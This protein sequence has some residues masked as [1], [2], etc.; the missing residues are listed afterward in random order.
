MSCR[1]ALT[2]CLVSLGVLDWIDQTGFRLI[3][4]TL[5][6]NNKTHSVVDLVLAAVEQQ[7]GF[8]LIDLALSY[9]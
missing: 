1:I 6:S 5:P 8:T 4:L 2:D 7:T 9:D 3:S